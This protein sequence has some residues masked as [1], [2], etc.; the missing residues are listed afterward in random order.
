MFNPNE[1]YLISPNKNKVIKK[2][3]ASLIWD[4]II[5]YAWKKGCPGLL[6][7]TI[8]NKTNPFPSLGP[9]QASNP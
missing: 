5:N 4:R 9:V 8:A 1:K 7:E 6:F 2:I 3:K